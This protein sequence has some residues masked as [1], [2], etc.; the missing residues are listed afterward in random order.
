MT[1]IES[2][3]FNLIKRCTQQ[4]GASAGDR[5]REDLAIDSMGFIRLIIE[6]ERTFGVRFEDEMLALD[7][8]ER[9]GDLVNYVVALRGC[10]QVA[11]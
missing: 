9:L 6:I 11:G 10:G 3:L 2:E 1:N 8:F 4:T 7:V 5:L